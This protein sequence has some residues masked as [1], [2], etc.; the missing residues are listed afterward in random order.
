[1][2]KTG[3]HFIDG[4]SQFLVFL[5][6]LPVIIVLLRRI[7]YSSLFILLALL[8]MLD[9]L[10]LLILQINFTSP[11]GR[12]SVIN[13]FTLLELLVYLQIFRV[14]FVKATKKWL[15]IIVIAL[16]SAMLTYY[17]MRG[18]GSSNDLL[19]IL[20]NGFIVALILAGLPSLVKHFDIQ[21][22]QSPLFWISTGTLFYLLI[23]L[24]VAGATTG[25]PLN[26]ANGHNAWDKTIVLNTASLVKY[27]FYCISALLYKS[28]GHRKIREPN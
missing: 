8:C 11:I 21:I 9:F 1:M 18:T 14:F 16:L 20:Q 24:V 2:F 4:F 26:L 5:P 17:L 13:I 22:F 3:I 6:L 19:T 25:S 28:T 27:L 23:W 15:D 10:Q 12:Y 7:Y